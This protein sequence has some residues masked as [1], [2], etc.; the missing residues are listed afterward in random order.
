MDAFHNIAGVSKDTI[1]AWLDEADA[2]KAADDE[3][4]PIP[5]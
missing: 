4:A 5:T 1:N 3:K 2:Q